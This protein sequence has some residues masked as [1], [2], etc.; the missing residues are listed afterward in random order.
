LI[1]VAALQIAG[2]LL[3]VLGGGLLVALL[4]AVLFG[5]TVMGLVGL[6]LTMAGRYYPT[7]PAR[8]MGKMSLSYGIA[9]VIAPAVTG[10]LA[11]RLGSC[12]DGLYLAAVVMAVGTVLLVLLRIAEA[13]EPVADGRTCR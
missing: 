12:R 1:L 9:L 5:A 11:A 4:G 7:N 6:V 8:M 13:R 2:I 3:P 10:W